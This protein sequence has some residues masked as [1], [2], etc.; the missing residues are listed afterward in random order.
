MVGTFS[1]LEHLW[2]EHFN[3]WSRLILIDWAEVWLE[4]IDGWSRFMVGAIYGWS[5]WLEHTHGWSRSMVGA[6]RLW[7]VH[8]IS[9]TIPDWLEQKCSN[10]N[11]CWRKRSVGVNTQLDYAPT[12]FLLQLSVCSNPNFRPTRNDPTRSVHR[13]LKWPA[14][15]ADYFSGLDY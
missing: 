11:L 4:Q 3:S 8:P 6:K 7:L 15:H 10:E 12:A 9:R 1:W 13:L 14:L 5:I 2:L